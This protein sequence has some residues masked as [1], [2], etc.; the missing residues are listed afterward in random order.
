M[1]MAAAGDA[2]VVGRCVTV[3]GGGVLVV[4]YGNGLRTDDGIGPAVAARLAG[5]PR[6]AESDVRSM[7]QLTPELAFD[8]SRVSL[9]VL[10][11]AAADVAAGEVVVRHLDPERVVG[12]AMTHHLDPAGLVGLAQEL[13]GA[14]PPVVVVSVGVSSLEIGDRLS[15]VV[16]GA[17]PRAADAVAAIVEA[18]IVEAASRA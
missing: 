10:V 8:A 12:Q 5:D 6:L 18:A 15:P 3:G 14:A 13:W 2:T 17:V 11:D 1:T 4:G 9:L 7:H 16:E